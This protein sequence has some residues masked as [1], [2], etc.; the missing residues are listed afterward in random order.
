MEA[1]SNLWESALAKSEAPSFVLILVAVL[2]AT[3]LTIDP[4]WRFT[5]NLITV[6]HEGGHALVAVLV[7]RRI[8]GI[9]LRADT[10]GVTISKGNPTGLGVIAVTSAGY[11]APATLG[12]ALLWFSVAGKSFLALLLLTVLAALM[13]LSVRNLFGFILTIPIGVALYYTLQLNPSVQTGVVTFLA[14]FL[15]VASMRPIIELQRSRL[16]GVAEES[17]ADQLQRLTFI[18]P[19]VAWVGWFALWSIAAI[20]VEALLIWKLLLSTA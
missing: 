7:G 3:V 4:F 12:L 2:V 14:V 6:V 18:I 19:G 8:S 20:A 13:F 11:T 15:S 1:L 5:R 10:S 17:D 16:A 9:K